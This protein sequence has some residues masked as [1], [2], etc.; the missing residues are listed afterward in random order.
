MK[1]TF[2][3]Y[4]ILISILLFTL[5][6]NSQLKA[7]A[8]P[9]TI[10]VGID[11]EEEDI[12]PHLSVYVDHDNLSEEEILTIQDKFSPMSEVN[13]DGDMS[14]ST[15]WIKFNLLNTSDVPKEL[16]LEVK[17]PH[18]SLVS[19][20]TPLNETL[21]LEET[22]G[23]SL[24]FNERTIK[25]RN[26]VFTLN[27]EPS[28]TITTYY[29]KIKTDSFF[30]APL[31]LWDPTSFAVNQSNDQISY[32][33]FYGTMIAM[34]IY[35]SFLFFSLR[36]RTYLYYILF[37]ASFTIMQAIW[38][39]FAFQWL[40][41]DSPW[42]ALRSNS[43]FILCSSLFAIQFAKHFLQLKS[44]APLLYKMVNGF[45]IVCAISLVTPLFLSVGTSTMVSTI[46]ATFF[47]VFI[48]LIALKVRL[49]TREARFFIAAWALL[50]VGVSINI[51][52]AYKV[53]PINSITLFAPK[54]GSLV[55][56][57][58]L[59]LGLADRIKR[60][61][62]EKESEAKKYFM[63]V[64]L[65]QSF[66]QM[67]SL[68]EH[69]LLAE[70]A[71]NALRNLT[72]FEKGVYLSKDKTTWHILA[73]HGDL[74]AEQPFNIDNQLLEQITY[75]HE[76]DPKIFGIQQLNG[77][78]LSIPVVCQ[79]HTGL[80]VVYSE[81]FYHLDPDQQE[82]ILPQ[83]MEQFTV[84]MENVMNYDSIKKSAMYDHL[85]QVLNRKHFL[86]QA[87]MVLKESTEVSVLL[88]DIDHFK[89]VNDTYGHT[90]GDQAIVFVANKI[91]ESLKNSGFVG[92]Y[93]G[94]EF[95][96]VLTNTNVQRTMEI[97]NVLRESFHLHPLT[98]D[99]GIEI[100]LTVSIGVSHQGVRANSFIDELI[101]QADDC[102]YRAKNLGRDRVVINEQHRDRDF[103]PSKK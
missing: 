11:F 4:H 87:N 80:L 74:S 77:T 64:L 39:G 92:R 48:I 95:I 99:H 52:A 14:N 63:Q 66:K 32:G 79:D 76:V 18:L 69:H 96:A 98:L 37:I 33:L 78:F 88:I 59:S 24:P 57:L 90:I 58:V 8:A 85:T 103:V 82:K 54:I 38:D 15:Y 62:I 100:F 19:L 47:V 91:A 51:L 41:G 73:Q 83:F 22:I 67:T 9:N 20:Y 97:S 89:Q 28:T 1:L 29:L 5:F 43:F 81:E 30:Q 36:E 46:I 6:L 21:K 71:I 10:E 31:T 65:Q 50:L 56:V 34:M 102:L 35:N 70:S 27:L 23:Y 93:G 94:E 45:T 61:T 40:W 55:E 68:K 42:W 12:T 75:T 2:K 60:I 72:K 84:L 101:Q 26:L 49:Q 16:L 17:K 86:D 25:H 3:K 7:Y 53:F 44:I 13:I